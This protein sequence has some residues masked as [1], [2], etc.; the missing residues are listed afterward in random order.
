M[1]TAYLPSP[2][3]RISYCAFTCIVVKSDFMFFLDVDPEEA[4][5]R[6]RQTQKKKEM[7]ESLEELK[8][9]RGKALSL[10]LTAD[11]LCWMQTDL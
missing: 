3:D 2:F 5:R 6:I 10:A 7:F 1:G 9:I 8:R 4:D 11:G